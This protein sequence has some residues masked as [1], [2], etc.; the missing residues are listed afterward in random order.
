MSH[1]LKEGIFVW[2][3]DK[4]IAGNDYFTKGRI[5]N[6]NGNKVTVETSNAVKTQ[7]LILPLN[8]CHMMQPGDNDVPD[9]CQLMYLS[10][11]TLLQNTRQ[12]FMKDVIYTYVGDILVAVN[13]FKRIPGIYDTSVMA[14]CRGKRLYNAP[15]GPHV[16][17]ISEKVPP[18]PPLTLTGRLLVPLAPHTLLSWRHCTPPLALTTEMR[19]AGTP[20]AIRRLSLSRLPPPT[21]PVATPLP[22][23]P[24]QGAAS[25]SPPDPGPSS[26]ACRPHRAQAYITMRK[27]KNNQCV[28]VSGES[29]AGKTETNRQL[30]NYLVWRGSDANSDNTLTQKIMDANPILEAFGNAKTTRNN[31]S[32]RFG[33]CVAL[34]TG[35]RSSLWLVSPTGPQWHALAD[36]GKVCGH[37]LLSL[38]LSSRNGPPP[39]L[40][41]FWLQV[42][43][44]PVQ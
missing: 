18:L 41:P 42:R 27:K 11:A 10:Q 38:S 4:A 23:R 33:R 8:E 3:K 29:G 22:P 44:D 2:V 31:N 20:S 39:T 5:L 43:P 32:S 12:R 37:G 34:A 14:Q 28:V 21:S 16:F 1:K 15:C 7:E 40:R 9:H 13:P 35:H 6:I 30:L 25:S 36:G 17:M 19:A 24:P 26:P